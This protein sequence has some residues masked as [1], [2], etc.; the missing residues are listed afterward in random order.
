MAKKRVLPSQREK[1]RYITLKVTTKQP[2]PKKWGMYFLHALERNLGVLN[3][4]KAG[5]KLLDT[6]KDG[7]GIIRVA[8]TQTETL[9]ATLPTLRKIKDSD[10]EA[11]QTFKTTGILRKAR[12]NIQ[13]K[14]N[15]EK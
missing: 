8:H 5:L 15:E 7:Y 12:T 4:A 13:A 6:T 2:L 1:K 10:I 3:T 11:I 9:L 14:R